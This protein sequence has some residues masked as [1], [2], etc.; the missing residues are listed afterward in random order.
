[1]A[2]KEKESKALPEGQAENPKKP[3]RVKRIVIILAILLITLSGAGIGAYWWFF[4]RTPSVSSAV[5]HDAPAGEAAKGAPGGAGGTAGA[6]GGH[7]GAAGAAGG[8]DGRIERQSDLPRSSGQVL[9]L[10]PIT[11]NI[12]DP[13]GRRYL[14][15]GMEVEVNADVSAAL[16]A[17]SPRI[18][19]AIIML[20]AGKTFNDISTPDGKV[21]LKAEVAARLN[22]ILGAQRVIRVYFTDFVVE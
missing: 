13:T 2:A 9:P 16:Q 10:P 11:V 21:L 4:I 6:G 22:Q 1:M 14:K 17:N 7:G 19:D 8:A 20:L 5:P 3:S 18:R 12:S 15:L